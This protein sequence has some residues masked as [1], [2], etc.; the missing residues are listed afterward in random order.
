MSRVDPGSLFDLFPFFELVR[1]EHAR[2]LTKF[3]EPVASM[4]AL[5]EEAGELAKAMLS[6]SPDR[7]L[8]EAVQVAVMAARVALEGDPTLDLYRERLGLAKHPPEG[9]IL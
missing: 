8:K 6:E 5:S 2:A 3:P 4:A 7:I 1:E 9:G